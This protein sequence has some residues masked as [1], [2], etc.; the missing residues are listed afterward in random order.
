MKLGTSALWCWSSAHCDGSVSG[1]ITTTN[2]SRVVTNISLRSRRQFEG[3]RMARSKY[4]YPAQADGALRNPY[5]ATNVCSTSMRYPSCFADETVTIGGLPYTIVYT[6]VSGLTMG[7]VVGHSAGVPSQLSPSTTSTSA[8]ESDA[9]TTSSIPAI[10]HKADGPVAAECSSYRSL[11]TSSTAA[12]PEAAS[13]TPAASVTSNFLT[14]TTPSNE[15]SQSS[16]T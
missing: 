5:A 1:N 2:G 7:S 9:Q 3:P 11:S 8:T 14:S 15:Y 4:T 10:C 16:E 13:P 6:T 12:G